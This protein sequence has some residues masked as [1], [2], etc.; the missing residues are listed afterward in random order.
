MNWAEGLKMELHC[1]T[2]GLRGYSR[3][4]HCDTTGLISAKISSE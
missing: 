1:D 3:E 4:L 2:T